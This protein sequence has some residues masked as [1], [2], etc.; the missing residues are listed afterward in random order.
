MQLHNGSQLIFSIQMIYELD[1]FGVW[2]E[3]TVHNFEYSININY[4][5]KLSHFRASTT[6]N[7]SV[8]KQNFGRK[9]FTW[10]KKSFIFGN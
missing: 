10:V 1:M 9:C 4:K 3:E 7:F 5:S 6:S 2:G 8:V